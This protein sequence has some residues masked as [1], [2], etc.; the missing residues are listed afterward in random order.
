MTDNLLTLAG[1]AVI[2][3]AGLAALAGLIVL[4]VRT[5]RRRDQ[6][7]AQ[8]QMTEL[9]RLQAETAV[10][11]E[12]MRDML[13]GRQA[14]LH[15]AVNERLDSVSH[16]LNQSMTTTRQHTV[17][18]LQK[19]AVASAI[20][21]EIERIDA[22]VTPQR[23]HRRLDEI[24]R[25]AQEAGQYGPAVRAEELL[26][27]SIGMWIDRSLQ[28]SGQLNDSHV[29]ALLDLARRRQAEPIDLADDGQG[30]D[31]GRGSDSE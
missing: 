1:A 25:A 18:N 16:H 9:A 27:K 17:E 10:R 30:H 11:I 15:R 6:E 28:L 23:V 8:A 14:E 29:T 4:A 7:A 21:A 22:E 19:P 20:K 12:G 2:V 26:G 24:G 3:L 31:R 5:L 13:A